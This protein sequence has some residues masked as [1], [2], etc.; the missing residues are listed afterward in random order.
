M[1]A[2]QPV[3]LVANKSLPANI[4][5]RRRGVG[6]AQRRAAQ[7]HLARPARRRASC[8]RDAQA[9]RRHRHDAHQLQRQ[10]ASADRRDRRARADHVRHLALGQALSSRRASSSSSPARA[11]SVWP[12]RRRSPTIAET[13]P[14]FSVAAINAM[15]GPAGIPAPVLEKLSADIRAV[16][17]RPNSPRRPARSAS[18]P[19]AT[20]RPSSTPGPAAR[21]RAGPRSRRR[22][23]SARTRLPHS[24]LRSGPHAE[25]HRSAKQIQPLLQARTALRCVS[26]HGPAVAALIL[27]D[28]RVSMQLRDHDA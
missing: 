11:P 15:Y 6:E 3:A 17:A 25:E 19:R 20:R 4:G 18:T 5:C 23:I 9:A 13:Y 14:G 1:V 7:L 16:V 24:R 12:T 21:S 28:A 27:R 26:K 22:R 8:R 10:R 2:T